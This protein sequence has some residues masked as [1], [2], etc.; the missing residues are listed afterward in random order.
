MKVLGR[1]L[2][3]HVVRRRSYHTCAASSSSRLAIHRY[4]HILIP[5]KRKESAHRLLLNT[6]H[7]R[8]YTYRHTLFAEKLTRGATT[9]SHC[10]ATTAGLFCS[11]RGGEENRSPRG[12]DYDYY[13]LPRPPLLLLMESRPCCRTRGREIKRERERGK[14]DDCSRSETVCV[15]MC[16]GWEQR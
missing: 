16:V 9:E 6:K 1:P 12:R 10:C 11:A 13:T 14:A 7:A 5:P 8:I 2:A 4:K 15:C 3:V